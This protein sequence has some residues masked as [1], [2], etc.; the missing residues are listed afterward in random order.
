MVTEVQQR[1][2]DEALDIRLAEIR[3]ER[4]WPRLRLC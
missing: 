1:Y 4:I 2:Y 3:D